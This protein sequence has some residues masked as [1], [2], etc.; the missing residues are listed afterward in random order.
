MSHLF[1]YLYGLVYRPRILR[2]LQAVQWH[3]VALTAD[4]A[5]KRRTALTCQ[6]LHVYRKED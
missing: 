3:R 4:R 1:A 6:Y 2:R 5:A